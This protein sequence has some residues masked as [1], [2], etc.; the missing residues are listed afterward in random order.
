MGPKQILPFQVTE[1]LGVMGM[2]EYSTFPKASEQ[3]PHRLGHCRDA[4]GIF[5]NPNRLGWQEIE[6]L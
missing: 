4:V 2:K 6:L 1:D 5:Y 3:E